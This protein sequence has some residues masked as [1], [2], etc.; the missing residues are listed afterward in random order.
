MTWL[1]ESRE[2]IK[3]YNEVIHAYEIESK[4]CNC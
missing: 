4:F 1:R 2:M 3:K